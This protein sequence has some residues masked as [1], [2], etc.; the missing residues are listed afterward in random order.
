M[1]LIAALAK[2]TQAI[3]QYNHGKESK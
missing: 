3:D 2:A 1:M